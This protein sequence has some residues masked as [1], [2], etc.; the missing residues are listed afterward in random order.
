MLI[1]YKIRVTVYGIYI[2]PSI[3]LP[4]L[5]IFVGRSIDKP[6]PADFKSSGEYTVGMMTC[7]VGISTSSEWSF[8]HD[9]AKG[10]HYIMVGIQLKDIFG[11]TPPGSFYVRYE[12]TIGTYNPVTIEAYVTSELITQQ[13]VFAHVT[14]NVL[15]YGCQI[16]NYGTILPG[17]A[18]ITGTAQ[19]NYVNNTSDAINESI[20]YTVNMMVTMMSYMI[21]M[22]MM[23]QM[24]S[25]LAAVR[26]A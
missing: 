20:R 21:M 14:F 17:T 6:L 19:S 4:S 12:I 16:V 11:L 7:L 10:P 5:D 22:Q 13:Q 18:P 25:T 24:M 2:P 9:F 1:P 3:I 26:I 8:S 23:M 15:D